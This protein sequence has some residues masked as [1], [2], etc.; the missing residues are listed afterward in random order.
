MLGYDKDGLEL[1]LTATYRDEYLD[2]LGGSPGEDRYVRD[3][4]QIDASAKYRIN[5]NFQVFADFVNINDEDYVAFQKGP[6]RDRLLQYETYS[7]TSK[8]GVRYTY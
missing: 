7:W 1:R 3:H 2:E 5:D 6:D 8:L 4:L